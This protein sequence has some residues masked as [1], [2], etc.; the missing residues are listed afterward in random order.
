VLK[1]PLN[2]KQPTNQPPPPVHAYI[3]RTHANRQDTH[4]QI[5]THLEDTHEEAENWS[6]V[7]AA[8]LAAT[9]RLSLLLVSALLFDMFARLLSYLLRASVISLFAG[10]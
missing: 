4:T 5:Y 6:V 9:T 3:N 10:T 7:A 8:G 1:V 2:P